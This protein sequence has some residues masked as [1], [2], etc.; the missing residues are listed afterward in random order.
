METTAHRGPDVDAIGYRLNWRG[1]HIIT[2]LTSDARLELYTFAWY[3]IPGRKA[4]LRSS[5]RRAVPL[6]TSRGGNSLRPMTEG[7]GEP[8]APVKIAHAS[9]VAPIVGAVTVSSTVDRAGRVSRVVMLMSP[10][11]PR[12]E[13]VR[14]ERTADALLPSTALSWAVQRTGPPAPAVAIRLDTQPPDIT[15]TAQAA[16]RENARM[17]PS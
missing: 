13:L 1:A 7:V 10:Y 4:T 3:S 16:A 8:Q 6:V 5:R 11:A 2:L 9:C 12:V 17:C 14:P 15:M